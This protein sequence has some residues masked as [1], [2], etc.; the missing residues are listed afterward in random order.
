MKVLIPI[1]AGGALN[2]LI[3]Q[4]VREQAPLVIYT[5]GFLAGALFVALPRMRGTP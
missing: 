5:V 2:M 4:L 1:I 3:W